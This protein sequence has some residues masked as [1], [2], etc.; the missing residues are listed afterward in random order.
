[1]PDLTY[2]E[3]LDALK[4]V[5]AAW[6][7]KNNADK[8]ETIPCPGCGGNLRVTMECKTTNQMRTVGHCDNAFCLH[9]DDL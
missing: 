5:L 3:R 7:A 4:P 9:W 8:S 6:C 2:K 1:M